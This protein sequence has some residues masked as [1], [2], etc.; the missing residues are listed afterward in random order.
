MYPQLVLIVEFMIIWHQ[1]LKAIL[2]FIHSIVPVDLFRTNTTYCLH[3]CRLHVNWF[4]LHFRFIGELFKLKM[5][6]ENIMH[7][8]LFKLLRA[9]D[10]ESLEC[11]CRLLSTIGKELDSDKAKVTIDY[12]L[13]RIMIIYMY[14]ASICKNWLGIYK[15]LSKLSDTVRTWGWGTNQ[16]AFL[17]DLWIIVAHSVM[18]LMITF[19]ITECRDVRLDGFISWPLMF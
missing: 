14:Q 6:T 17:T 9:K 5:L 13:N 16:W 10:E 2:S 12:C 8:C 1:R 11:L 19:F 7:D 4:L 18:H 15:S 3:C